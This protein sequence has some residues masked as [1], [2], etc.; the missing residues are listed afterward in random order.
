MSLEPDNP[1]PYDG[2][3]SVLLF[4]L[5]QPA[6]AE[7]LAR[8][9]I[10]LAS[11]PQQDTDFLETTYST[12]IAALMAQGKFA[13][14]REGIREAQQKCPTESMRALVANTLKEFPPRS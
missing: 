4:D 5:D 3:A 14:A 12:L 2:K 9:A 10:A 7:R 8:K 1:E 13:A 6:E 11:R